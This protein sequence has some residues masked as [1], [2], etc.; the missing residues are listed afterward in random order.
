[1]SQFKRLDVALRLRE[2]GLLPIFYHPDVEICKKVI[3]ACY[4]GGLRIIE[5]TNRDD[6]AHEKYAELRKFINKNLPDMMFGAGTI[7]DAPTA[8]LYIQMGADF[9]VSPILNEEMA[10]V[11]N[12]RKILWVPGCGSL[13]EISFAE[14]L[15]AEIVKAFPA[16]T[17]G[18]PDFIKAVTAPCKWTSILVTG[19]ASPEEENMRS[20][21]KAGA[22]CLGMGSKLITKDVL[23]NSDFGL[24]EK[25]IEQTLALINKIR[26]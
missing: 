24:L 11:C 17:M 3:T 22:T 25:Q 10:K 1:M 14:E 2:T 18:G 20:W 12:R 16:N 7:V 23:N 9:I 8:S 5:Y 6:F 21:F 4:N 26:N 15:G 13:S 19:G